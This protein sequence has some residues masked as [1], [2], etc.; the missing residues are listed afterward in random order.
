MGFRLRTLLKPGGRDEST[1]AC[2]QVGLQEGI[3]ML[4]VAHE[5]QN[6]CLG[7]SLRL[8]LR[9]GNLDNWRF[10]HGF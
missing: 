3:G 7:V 9:E 8:V 1:F 2:L 10:P 6:A 4:N 5:F